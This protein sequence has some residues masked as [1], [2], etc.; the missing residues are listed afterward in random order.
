[1]LFAGQNGFL[2]SKYL[3]SKAILYIL[4]KNYYSSDKSAENGERTPGVTGINLTAVDLTQL[5]LMFDSSSKATIS[6]LYLRNLIS[7][8]QSKIAT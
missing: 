2:D 1:M 8:L 6:Q 7:F 5:D 4:T 3:S